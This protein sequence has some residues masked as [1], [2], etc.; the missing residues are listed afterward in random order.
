MNDGIRHA[1]GDM[2]AFLDHDDGWFPDFLETQV[3]YLEC[4]PDVGMV[5]S[6]FQTTDGDGNVLEASVAT[7]RGRTRPSGHVFPQLFLDS[8]IVGNSVL[9]R[10]EC[11]DKVGIFDEGLRW[12]DYHMW[13]R[14]ARHYKVDYV[15]KVLTKYRQH[16]T[17]STRNVSVDTP[18]CEPVG[19]AATR[20]ML[21]AYPEVWK[22]LGEK[23]VKRRM[24]QLYSD[25]AYQSWSSGAFR[26]ARRA[27]MRAIRLSPTSTRYYALLAATLLR[28]SHSMALRDAWRRI[29]G[30]F[31]SKQAAHT[32]GHDVEKKRD[33]GSGIG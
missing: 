10:R 17:Q 29:R 33:R 1:T 8:F 18:Y 13:M 19:L 20:K 21:E 16:Q 14:I 28:P 15:D 11:F 32:L 5:H 2:I 23:V 24:A 27:I 6:D 26:N 4:H 7:S 12:G 9:I 25:L 30:T 22:E 31:S 3:S